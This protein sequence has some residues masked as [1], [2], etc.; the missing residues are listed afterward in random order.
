MRAHYYEK[1]EEAFIEDVYELCNRYPELEM[2]LV[3]DGDDENFINISSSI[4]GVYFDIVFNNVET[5]VDYYAEIINCVEAFDVREEVDSYSL[6][7]DNLG[8]S[9][10]DIRR[11]VKEIKTI[12]DDIG[13]TIRISYLTVTRQYG[14]Y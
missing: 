3:Y 11:G 12:L 5:P 6:I 4:D 10:S 8:L 9:K 1:L 14:N 2:G 13:H 7:E